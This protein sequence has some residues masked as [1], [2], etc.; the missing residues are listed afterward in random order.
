LKSSRFSRFGD[1]LPK[2][3]R[4]FRPTIS[5]GLAIGAHRFIAYTFAR[6]GTALSL[7]VGDYYPEGKQWLCDCAIK[8]ASARIAV[9]HVLEEYMD[10]RLTSPGLS[11]AKALPPSGRLAEKPTC[12]PRTAR[13]KRRL[14]LIVYLEAARKPPRSGIR[15]GYPAARGGG[16]VQMEQP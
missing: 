3:D 10:A 12:S 2:G 13:S 11:D 1:E 8:A 5:W 9:H 6:V 7:N 15:S 16:E 14:P 4:E